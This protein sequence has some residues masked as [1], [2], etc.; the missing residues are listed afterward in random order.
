[1]LF[2]VNKPEEG[3]LDRIALIGGDEDKALLLV[4]DAISFG[5]EHW[6]NKLED[7]DVEDIYVA[8]NA[9]DARNLELSDNCQVV[10]YPEMVDLLLGSDEK[11]VSL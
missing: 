3:I 1:M 7:L 4:G 6:E 2:F 9:L 5:T 10:D 11:I 8:K